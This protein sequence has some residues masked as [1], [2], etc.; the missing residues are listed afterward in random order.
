[1]P[2]SLA[3]ITL[4]RELIG[5]QPSVEFVAGLTRTVEWIAEYRSLP[6]PVIG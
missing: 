4:A 3:D 5:Y 1:V 2:E 6:R